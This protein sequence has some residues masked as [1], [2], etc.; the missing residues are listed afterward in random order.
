MAGNSFLQCPHIPGVQ[1]EPLFQMFSVLL[2]PVKTVSGLS[3]SVEGEWIVNPA[4]FGFLESVS[5]LSLFCL[6]FR[7]QNYMPFSLL[8]YLKITTTKV[9]FK[10]NVR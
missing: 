4:L 8:L 6:L 7:F 9:H 3:V 5:Q 10:F 1:A 2:Y